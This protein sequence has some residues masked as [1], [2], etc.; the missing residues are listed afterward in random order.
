MA[1]RTAAFYMDF[2][3]ATPKNLQSTG[4]LFYKS[5]DVKILN[6]PDRSE[7]NSVLY[8]PGKSGSYARISGFGDG[9]PM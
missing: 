9:C 4:F 6:V 8:L 7:K 3:T 5:G 2:N 1:E